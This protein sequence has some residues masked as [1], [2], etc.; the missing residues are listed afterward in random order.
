MIT[1]TTTLTCKFKD[2]LGTS[3]LVTLD[4]PNE[5]ITTDPINEFTKAAIESNVL[6][7]SEKQ[8]EVSFLTVEGASITHKTVENLELN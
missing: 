4:N 7:V 2:T 6:I 5:N 1:Q 3:K 8:P